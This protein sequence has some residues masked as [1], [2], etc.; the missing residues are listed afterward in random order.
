MKRVTS[1]GAVILVPTMVAGIYGMNFRHM[2]ELGWRYG[3]PLALVV[4]FGTAAGVWYFFRRKD[5]L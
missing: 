2:P 1:W 4:M 5:W 3:Y